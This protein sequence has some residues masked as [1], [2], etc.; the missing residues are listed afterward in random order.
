MT[1]NKPKAVPSS[2]IVAVFV[3]GKPVGFCEDTA[4][5]LAE[6]TFSTEIDEQLG[7][8]IIQYASRL[9]SRY[10]QTGSNV[11]TL[12]E[13]LAEAR[14]YVISS[15]EPVRGGFIDECGT[16]FEVFREHRGD[17]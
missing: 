13:L 4:L 16:A 15:T 14:Y 6:R 10:Q 8:D 2:E 17:L 9:H 1:N 11:A 7:S 12:V 5:A 3:Q